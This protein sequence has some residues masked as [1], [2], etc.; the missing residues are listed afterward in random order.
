MDWSSFVPDLIVSGLTTGGIAWLVLTAERRISDR[1]SSRAALKA[2][3]DAV[4]GARLLLDHEVVYESDGLKPQT[5]TLKRLRRLVRDVPADRPRW[6]VVGYH[7]VK[8]AAEIASIQDVLIDAIEDH[9]SRYAAILRSDSF[10]GPT[11]RK[12]VSQWA[13]VPRPERWQSR[14]DQPPR[15]WDWEGLQYVIE[16]EVQAQIEADDELAQA[17]DNYIHSRQ[18]LAVYREAFNHADVTA[19]SDEWKAS[20]A[21]AAGAPHNRAQR[22]WRERKR[23][24]A[25]QSAWERADAQGRE[26]VSAFDPYAY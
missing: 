9:I 23:W 13:S 25:V 17:I 22:W 3:T 20:L 14:F 15:V 8:Q 6:P 16:P 5:R 10:V 19:R 26:M 18:M 4:D 12:H 24:S 7:F 2:Q 21:A 1:A 11:I